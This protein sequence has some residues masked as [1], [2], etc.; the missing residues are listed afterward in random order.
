MLCTMIFVVN[1]Y[2]K[3]S[4]CGIELYII[5][6]SK[7]PSVYRIKTF[8]IPRNALAMSP[9]YNYQIVSTPCLM[10]MYC[11]IN[12]ATLGN[13]VKTFRCDEYM[14]E[15]KFI[16]KKTTEITVINTD[17]CS[18]ITE[19]QKTSI[20]V[21]LNEVQQPCFMFRNIEFIHYSISRI[22]CKT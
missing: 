3:G 20:N 15:R 6:R 21:L 19:L 11:N 18:V 16:T 1:I 4:V 5:S 2:I 9:I 22:Y 13:P 14:F 17:G 12:T 7:R 10:L 8:R